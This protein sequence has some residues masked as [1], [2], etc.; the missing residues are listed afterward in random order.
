MEN[1]FENF[2]IKLKELFDAKDDFYTII[3]KGHKL[4]EYNTEANELSLEACEYLICSDGSVN[5]SNKKILENNGF[6]VY[7][8]EKDSFGWLV[9]AIGKNNRELIFG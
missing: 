6:K 7:P 5:Y 4:V 2:I 8:K 3:D 1:T 9:G